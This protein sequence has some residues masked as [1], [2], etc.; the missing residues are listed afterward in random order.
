MKILIFSDS[1]GDSA[2]MCNVVE[3][4]RP[5]MIIYLGDGIADAEEVGQKYPRIQMIT[6]LGGLDSDKDDEQWIKYA[7][8]CGKRFMMTHGHTFYD[9]YVINQ[10]GAYELTQSGMAE[11]QQNIFKFMSENNVD[12][13]LH[14]HIHE[15]FVYYN[16]KHG[17]IMC[18]GRIGR[19][20]ADSVNPIYGVLKIRE[21][22]VLEWQFIEFHIPLDF[23]STE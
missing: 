1:H 11:A 17:W 20:D 10:D 18:P 15:P 7:D 16:L 12:I 6:V 2:T 22:G 8:I 3:K 23:D 9:N 21:S 13:T 5:D 4:E 14:G 19:N